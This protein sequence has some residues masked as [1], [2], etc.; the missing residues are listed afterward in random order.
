MFLVV[1]L[2]EPSTSHHL[3][4]IL[5][6]NIQSIRYFESVNDI[7]NCHRNYYIWVYSM[8]DIGWCKMNRVVNT[9]PSWGGTTLKDMI[10]EPMDKVLL[11][12][13][14]DFLYKNKNVSDIIRDLKLSLII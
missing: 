9:N 5:N 1:S 12:L 7:K 2:K 11:E 4:D 10:Q 6:D 3:F 8:K 13:D 14:N